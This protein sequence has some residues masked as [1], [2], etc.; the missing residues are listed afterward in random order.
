[1]SVN[2]DKNA[3][4]RAVASAQVCFMAVMARRQVSTG[5]NGEDGCLWHG[6]SLGER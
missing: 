6:A 3:E 2:R 1:M 5:G 4:L